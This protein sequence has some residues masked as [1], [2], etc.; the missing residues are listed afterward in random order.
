LKT[1][2]R[3][4]LEIRALQE[5]LTK[6]SEASLRINE[7]LDFDS[8][9]QDVV[10]SARNLTDAR[11]GGMTVLDD[12]GR[13]ERF[14]T[15]GLKD[16]ER[17]IL[18]EL[19]ES[20]P[21]FRH[22]NGVTEPLRIDDLSQY[23][24]SLDLSGWHPPVAVTSFLVAPVRNGGVRMGSLYLTKGQEGR[25][26]T[27]EDEETLVMFASQAALVIANARRYSDEQ[28]ARADLEALV[29][30]SPVGVVVF[31]AKTG[32]PV[33]HNRETL[34]I[35]EGLLDPNR[36]P[37]QIMEILSLRRMDGREVSLEESSLAD[38]LSAGRT[39][40]AEEIVIQAP[41]GRSVT[42]LVNATPIYSGD[43]ADMESVVVTL[44]DMTP[45]EELERLRAEFLGMVSHELRAPL[46][47]VKGSAATLL[48]DSANLNAAEMRQFHRIINEQADRM[49]RIITDLL[50]VAHIETGMLSVNPEPCSA[51]VLVD[52]AKTS[53]VS[54]GGGNDL[55]IDLPPDLPA[56]MADRQRIAQVLSNLLANAG[57]YSREF[58]TVRLRAERQGLHLAF[59]V[60]DEGRGVSA[61]RLPYL[62]RKYV[63]IEGDSAG[64]QIEGS[65]LGLAICKGIVEAHGGRIWAESE[66]QGRGARFTFTLP[67][68]EQTESEQTISRQRLSG[69][70]GHE[71]DEHA[72]ILVVDDDP[73]TLR[74]VRDVL[75]RAGYAP[76]V[77]ADPN[78]AVRL[79]ESDRP[80]LV[81]LDLVFPDTDGVEL[82]Q[83]ILDIA[84]VPVIFLTAY[85]RDQ[86]IERAFDMGA[87]DYMAKPFSP[88]ELTA[89]IKAALRKHAGLDHDE[90]PEPFALGD[91]TIDY[92]HRRVH[93]A[94]RQV[95]LTPI[96][97]DLLRILSVNAGRALSHD[98]LL[99]RVWHI[100]TAGDPQV[101]RTHLRRL[102]R[103]L[104]DDADNPSYIFTEP[105]VGYRMP[106]EEPA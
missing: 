79:M 43:G 45:L 71:V 35:V 17:R 106:E 85:G 26:F 36:P 27:R 77:T 22:L 50:D 12:E 75:S 98:Q 2:D 4:G 97:Y 91:L 38:R 29:N 80:Q 67:V 32:V 3:S 83:D 30:T 65:G 34:R 72:R 18:A 49:R 62:F 96:E 61:E 21:L 93:V 1:E 37:E 16:E 46:T 64:R 40:R 42:T 19:P 51:A 102:R 104:G 74:H 7:N 54:G 44:Q 41:D 24:R 8:V 14:V 13:F 25:E 55:Q 92:F 90:P 78:E 73:Q 60:T 70:R 47:S 94:G 105:G 10:D 58:S 39:I 11:Y 95:H 52:H 103:K 68:A 82:M 23:L 81:L 31:D 33:S 88:T 15:S 48:D 63:R 89:R 5:R 101:V 9:L 6:L 56:V 100:T 87:A 53:F 57:K 66:G 20:A 59:S 99:R 76:I 86:N 84:E 28:R 69:R